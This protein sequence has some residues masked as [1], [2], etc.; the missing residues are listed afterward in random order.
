MTEHRK[1]SKERRKKGHQQAEVNA[2]GRLLKT[3]YTLFRM[4][5]K[6]LKSGLLLLPLGIAVSD[7]ILGVTKVCSASHDNEQQPKYYQ[8][9]LVV[10]DR[11]SRRFNGIQVNDK[12]IIINPYDAKSRIIRTVK[13]LEKEWVKVSDT[14]GSEFMAFVPKGYLWIENEITNPMELDSK[15]FGPIPQG[16]VIGRPMATLW[17]TN[18]G[19]IVPIT[20]K[21]NNS[22]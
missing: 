17:R 20:N 4:L 15:E 11:I 2:S 10:V 16:L 3:D 21:N 14:D 5:Y 8:E 6:S 12:I 19:P 1:V 18:K 7:T 22:E 13:G 9:A